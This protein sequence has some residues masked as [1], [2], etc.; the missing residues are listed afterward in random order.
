[1]MYGVGAILVGLTLWLGSVG[2]WFGLG[3]F[4]LFV[5]LFVPL[6]EEPDMERRFGDAYREYCRKVPR[7]WPRMP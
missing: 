1:M 4:V 2:L 3:G 5:S 7:W 6:Y